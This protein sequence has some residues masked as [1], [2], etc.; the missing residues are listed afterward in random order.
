ME[1]EIASGRLGSACLVT[2]TGEVDVYTA[3]ELRKRLIEAVD[4]GSG[5]L[6]VDMSAVDFIDSSGLG[7][8]VSI[9]KRVSEQGQTMTIVSDREIVLKVFNITCLD[10]VFPIVATLAEATGPTP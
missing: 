3:P 5:S 4:T 8:L 6:V 9:L 10:R 7:V 2:L 1:L